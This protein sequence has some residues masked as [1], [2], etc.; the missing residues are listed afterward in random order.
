[1][2]T[3][4]HSPI[5]VAAPPHRRRPR[6][7]SRLTRFARKLPVTISIVVLMIIVVYPL[8]WLFLSS[9]KTQNEFITAP[10][11][12]LPTEWTFDNY[13]EAWTTGNIAGNVLN[14]ILVTVPSLV[15]IIVFGVAAGYALEVLVWRGRNQVLLLF[16]AGIM[17]PGQMILVPLFIVYFR[18]GLTSTLWPLIITY[19]ALGLSLTVFMMAAYFRSIPKEIFEAATL[20]GSSMLRSFFVIALPM[21][22]N[23]IITIALV[24][25]FNIWNDLLIA[26]TFTTNPANATVQVGLLNFSGE[27]GSLQYGPLFAGICIN[28]GGLL[29]LYLFLNQQIMK[30]LA[31]GAVKG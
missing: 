4:T 26:L 31:S 20:D 14:S 15:I 24:Q 25:F 22:K 5:A 23:A 13:V 12:A 10:V 27:Y 16:V 21:M 7:R 28:V 9:L 29:V 3:M 6:F 19:S 8:V 17:I 18:I 11:W 2:T 1:M 30:G